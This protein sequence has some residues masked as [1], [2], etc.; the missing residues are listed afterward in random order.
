MLSFVVALFATVATASADAELTGRVVVPA[1]S[2]PAVVFLQ[3]VVGQPRS[4]HDTVITHAA[5]GS[6]EPAVAVG[7][8]GN[9][10]IFKNDDDTLHTTHLYLHLAYQ[11]EI[12]G[13]PLRNGATLYNIALPLQDMEVRRPIK[14]YFEFTDQTG[15]IDVRCNPHPDEAATVLVFDHPYAAVSAANGAF[16]IPDV[17]AGTHEVW[18]WHDGEAS[19]WRSV[20][21]GASGA[22]EVTVEVG[23]Q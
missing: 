8:V 9:Q 18:V 10:F 13:R 14:Q 23:D 21:V 6:F 12:S 4:D 20:E 11:R 22:T 2:G 19:L 17:P 3:G 15:I 7:F 5:D 1:G 16:T